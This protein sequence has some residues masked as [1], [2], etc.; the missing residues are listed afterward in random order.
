MFS[1]T[2]LILQIVQSKNV[3]SMIHKSLSNSFVY[4]PV[5]KEVDLFILSIEMK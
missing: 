4:P 1:A 3:L 5:C 2:T